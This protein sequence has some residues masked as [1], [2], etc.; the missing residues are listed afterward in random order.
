[1]VAEICLRV[2]MV[3]RNKLYSKLEMSMSS[4]ACVVTSKEDNII[5]AKVKHDMPS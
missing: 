4:A 3:L 1:M 5:G 2:C